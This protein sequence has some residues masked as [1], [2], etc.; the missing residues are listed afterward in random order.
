MNAIDEEAFLATFD[1]AKGRP[2]FYTLQNLPEMQEITRLGHELMELMFPGRRGD[3]P[4][5]MTL[6]G[7][8]RGQLHL[9]EQLLLVQI[10][11]AYDYVDPSGHDHMEKA[12]DDVE[13][14]VKELPD[15][16]RTLKLDARAGYEGDPAARDVRD[17]ILAYPFI[18]AVTVYR[19][20]H[21]LYKRQVPI[22]PRML[23][24]SAHQETG[25]DINPGAQI[26]PAFFIDHGT[27]VVIGETTV[28][29]T[30]VK[31]Y[32]GVTLGALSFPRDACGVLIRGAKRH[33]TIKDN[34][35]IYSHATILGD[36]TIGENAVIGAGVWIRDDVPPDTMVTREDPKMI[37]RD[38]SK[39]RS[40]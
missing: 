39:R 32:Q 16:R 15:I 8:I 26:G 9:V 3:T 40:G 17:I 33:P 11:L 31:L 7:K 10:K 35:T 27:G 14:L 12:H 30:H 1:R 4:Q 28:I 21:V 24:E 37:F 20:A 23:T 6:D 2:D 5:G 19:V 13:A 25:I 36:I 38:L 22:V 18:K 34:V 29:G